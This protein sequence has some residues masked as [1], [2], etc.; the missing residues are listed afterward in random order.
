MAIFFGTFIADRLGY[1]SNLGEKDESN[2]T[3][4]LVIGGGT[5]IRAAVEAA[6][7]GVDVTLVN[8]VA[9][10]AS[11]FIFSRRPRGWEI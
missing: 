4:V 2:R 1:H 7:R 6:S 5:G 3:D 11:G 9:V 8:G 10:T